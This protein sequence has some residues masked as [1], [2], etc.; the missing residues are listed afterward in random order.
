MENLEIKQI[1][2][3]LEKQEQDINQVKKGLS[4][5]L[6]KSDD[7]DVRDINQDLVKFIRSFIQ[8]HTIITKQVVTARESAEK[9]KIY[10]DG[11]LSNLP[12]KTEQHF[13]FRGKIK[14]QVYLL[15]LFVGFVVTTSIIMF[16]NLSDNS[17]YE[18]AWDALIKVQPD[19]AHKKRLLNFLKEY[20]ND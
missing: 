20:Q 5:L 9:I 16:H 13:I 18:K 17:N 4:V 6:E 1:I 11:I 2:Q 12:L 3:H 8:K 15:I 7:N 19:E 10:F 14:W